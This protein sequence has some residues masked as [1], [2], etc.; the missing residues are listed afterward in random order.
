MHFSSEM[1]GGGGLLKVTNS[2]YE[3]KWEQ[4]VNEVIRLDVVRASRALLRHYI[5][6]STMLKRTGL[7]VTSVE[8]MK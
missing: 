8:G 2:E 1:D 7:H 4:P 6:V 5:S 3:Y